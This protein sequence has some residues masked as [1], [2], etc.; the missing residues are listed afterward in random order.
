MSGTSPPWRSTISAL[1]W[2]IARVL[3]RKNPVG[4]I[5]SSSSAG[6]TER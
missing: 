6:S 2:R 5:I 3:L 1:A 4:R